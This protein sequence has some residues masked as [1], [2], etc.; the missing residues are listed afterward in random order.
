MTFSTLRAGLLALSTVAVAAAPQAQNVVFDDFNDDDFSNAFVFGPNDNAGIGRFDDGGQF[1]VGINPAEVGGFAVFGL[2]RPGDGVIDV[3]S[4]N[5]VSFQFTATSNEDSPA[6]QPFTLEVNLQEDLDGNGTFDRATEDEFQANVQVTVDGATRTVTLPLSAFSDDNSND[7]GGDGQFDFSRLRFVVF[8]IAGTD[9][10]GGAFAVRTDNIT[11]GQ[12]APAQPGTVVIK[13]FDGDDPQAGS[14]QFS[15]AGGAGVALSIVDGAVGTT[16]ALRADVDGPA[17]GGFAGFG[18]PVASPGDA[19]VEALTFY[20]RTSFGAS[21]Q[22]FTLEVNLQE[23]ADGSGAFDGTGNQD[24]EIQANVSVAASSAGFTLVSIPVASFRDDNSNGQMG[25]GQFD[26][27]RL[28]Q[29]VF[30]IGGT[31]QL[32]DAFSLDVDQFA[33]AVMG[34]AGEDAP[35]AVDALRTYPNP[36]AGPATVSFG[37]RQAS[38]V[39]VTVV[40][41]LGRR[42]ATVAAGTRSAGPVTL[43]VPTAGLAAGVYGVVVQTAEGVAT[44]RMTV[45]R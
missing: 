29:V 1:A 12:G 32:G 40:D 25:N 28:L 8:A 16:G 5:Q 19:E 23:D 2:S 36:T 24:D 21:T 18:F 26:F 45:V 15:G 14:F 27:S 4:T 42:V 39:T 9:Q 11:F 41:L 31:D 3:S 20:L 33:F 6:T 34:T 30:A 13:D 43:A 35:L 10:L 44:T 7:A 38:D 17:A 22:P 37:L